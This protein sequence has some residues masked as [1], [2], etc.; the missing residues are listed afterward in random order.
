[1]KRLLFCVVLTIT[2]LIVLRIRANN[3][4]DSLLLLVKLDK[5]DTEKIKLNLEIGQ[6]FS[7]F[8]PDSA[9]L[10]FK[11]AL[12]IS[13]KNNL[14]KDV[15]NC[16]NKIAVLYKNIGNYE[17]AKGYSQGSLKI[18][19][20]LQDKAGIAIC[21]SNLGIIFEEQGLYNKA[22]E[23]YLKALNIEEKLGD[24]MEMA[25][26]YNNI[27]AVFYYLDDYNNAIVYYLKS[28][29]IK[30]ENDDKKGM[31]VC[32]GNIGV[33]FKEQ[34]NFDKA[35]T[36]DLKCLELY[37]SLGIKKGIA[38]CF[39]NIGEVYC[40][41]K[42]YVKATAYYYESLLIYKYLGD[43][44]GITFEYKNIAEIDNLTNNYVDAINNAQ[45]G[46]IIAKE[47]K[48]ENLEMNNYEILSLAYEGNRDYKKALE[49]NKLYISLKDSIFSES[50]NKLIRELEAKYQN[51]KKQKEIEILEKDEKLKIAE[52]RRMQ[53]QKY[54]FF[55][56]FLLIMLLAVLIF[57][58]YK[59]KQKNNLL[60]LERKNDKLLIE[61]NE[62]RQKHMSEVVNIQETERKHIAE[63]LHDELGGALS[64]IKV[65]LS[66]WLYKNQNQGQDNKLLK[67]ESMVDNACV[68]VRT[69]AHDLMP[70]ELVK[71]GFNYAIESL[72]VNINQNGKVNIQ[73]SNELAEK[74]LKPEIEIAV[75]RIVNELLTNIL[76]HSKA[77]NASLQL[78]V[79]EGI[80]TVIAE[81][82]GVGFDTNAMVAGMGLGNIKSRVAALNG[83]MT[84]D[85]SPNRGSSFL[86]D[87]PFKGD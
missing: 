76:R 53:L 63:N 36:Y 19:E 20:K 82:N 47:I 3:N 33:I 28:L 66:S 42:D 61:M 1:M 34:L 50:K 75:Y 44:N 31:A 4:I 15:A 30:E 41:K 52:I 86:I 23:Y 84:I 48:S 13:Q 14:K 25:K 71:L 79:S 39:S 81:D 16:L 35:L 74:Q 57:R 18:Y 38:G 67:I 85:S 87:I 64:A 68:Q 45:K 26:S 49:Y 22:M 43:K 29:K 77:Q 59:Q 5:A 80:L 27:G 10:F 78:F 32:Y 60:Q 37:E 2:S 24:K 51:E 65:N 58:S 6:Y 62:Q 70:P 55:G 40:L 12:D 83:S 8:K 9:L 21:Y 56:G 72:V 11:K 69:I 54:I 17:K 46:L 73:L 7:N